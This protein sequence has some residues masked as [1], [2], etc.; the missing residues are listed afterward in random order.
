MQELNGT[1]TPADGGTPRAFTVRIGTP[2][3]G[4][5]SWCVEFE[6]LGFDEPHRATVQGEDWAQAIELVARVLPVMLHCKVRD[7]GGGTLDPAFY[8]R[9]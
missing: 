4:P 8:E 1:F 3:R 7:A 2:Y 5:T 9:D 6:V